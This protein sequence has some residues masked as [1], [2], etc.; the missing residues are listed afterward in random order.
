M[1]EKK[2]NSKRNK[3]KI[4][5]SISAI[6]G[7]IFLIKII[8]NMPFVERWWPVLVGGIAAIVVVI[9]ALYRIMSATV[10]RKARKAGCYDIT[11]TINRIDTFTGRQ[12]EF[13]CADLLRNNGYSNVT[14]TP[15]SNDQGVDIIAE[16]NG[17]KY[18]FQ[19]KRYSSNLGNTPIQEVFAGSAFYGCNYAVVMTNSF[20]TLGAIEAAT[21][22]GVGLWDRNMITN[23]M[24][25]ANKRML[26]ERKEN[27]KKKDAHND[28]Y[29]KWPHNK[30]SR[31]IDYNYYSALPSSPIVPGQLYV[32]CNVLGGETEKYNPYHGWQDDSYMVEILSPHFPTEEAAEHFRMA[33]TKKYYALAK[34]HGNVVSAYIHDKYIH[35]LFNAEKCVF[36]LDNF[37]E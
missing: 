29:D 17:E 4:S 32:A 33:I 10:E 34:R 12:F 1:A 37:C 26:D 23:L 22:I 9:F 21:K 5:D 31:E 28:E 11:S 36:I 7:G 19:C 3:G 24:K 8:C 20:F 35:D 27:R 30:S 6:V 13:W 25:E 15:S 18:A 16:C 14:V 2:K